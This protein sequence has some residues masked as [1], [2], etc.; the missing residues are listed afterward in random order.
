MGKKHLFSEYRLTVEA[1]D[2]DG[3][4]LATT[5]PLI[6]HVLDIND[7][8]PIFQDTP[9]QFVLTQDMRNFTERAFIKVSR[10][11][12]VFQTSQIP[13]RTHIT[14]HCGPTRLHPFGKKFFKTARTK[15]ILNPK[16]A[17]NQFLPN[18][19]TLVC[20]YK[21][22]RRGGFGLWSLGGSQYCFI[23]KL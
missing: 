23:F 6:I 21:S 10:F 18:Y 16:I 22:W 12:P 11:Y 3:S 14:H 9:I 17:K 2:M 1:R 4:G 7:E 8:T 20:T 5:V 19:Y 15:R 13:N